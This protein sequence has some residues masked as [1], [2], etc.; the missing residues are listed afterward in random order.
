MCVSLLGQITRV[1]GEH[2]V[3]DVGGIERKASLAMLLLEDQEVST[4]D[5]VLIHTGFAVAVLDPDEA[6]EL[7]RWRYD[8]TTSDG[9]A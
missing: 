3:V 5:W 8:L 4:G 2:A 7:T 1:N 9:D 6:A